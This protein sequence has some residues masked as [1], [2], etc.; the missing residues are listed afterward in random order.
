MLIIN[1]TEGFEPFGPGVKPLKNELFPSGSE[2]RFELAE[3]FEQEGGFDGRVLLTVR[4]KTSDC[5]M[6]VLMAADAVKRIPGV[7]EVELFMPYFPYARQDRVMTYGHPLSARVMAGLINS[8]GFSRVMIYDVHSDVSSA[9]LDRCVS[10]TNTAFVQAV[11]RDKKDYILLSP[12]AG[13]Y[14]KIQKLGEAVG[15]EGDI[16]TVSKSRNV[17][18]GYMVMSVPEYDFDSRDIYIIDDIGEGCM[19]FRLI[20]ERLLAG[21]GKMKVGKINLVLSHGV[22]S[23]KAEENMRGFI[24]QVYTTDS[25]A[26]ARFDFVT[27]IPLCPNILT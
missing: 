16:V 2:V 18:T 7:R 5:I 3:G 9:L 21:E 20:A 27:E 25:F 12:D 17:T 15:F 14:K 10:I 22:F 11:L 4:V 13:A 19:S 8:V 23:G 6:K 24:D 1:L 26:G